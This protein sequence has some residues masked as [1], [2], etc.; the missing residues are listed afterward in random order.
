MTH[1]LEI[2]PEDANRLLS[3]EGKAVVIDVREPWEFAVA[4]LPN[5][6]LVPMGT[7]PAELQQLD[8]LAEDKTLL[9][10]CHHGVR[11]LQVAAWLRENG[12]DECYSVAGGIDRWSRD[13][14]RSI[15]LY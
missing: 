12:V 6:R 11:S 8:A 13:I 14:D 5:A 9:L 1:S 2:S 7:V 4:K 15:P 10:L 3:T